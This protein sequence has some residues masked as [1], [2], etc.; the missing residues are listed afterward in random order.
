MMTPSLW[1]RLSVSLLLG[2][3]A[4]AAQRPVLYP[5]EQYTRGGPA[6]AESA[7]DDCMRRASEFMSS[8]SRNQEAARGVATETAVGAGAGAAIGAVGG[9]ISGGAGEGAAVGAATGGTAGFLHGMFRICE[10]GGPPD[11]T[12]AAFVDRCLREKGYE[13]IGW[14]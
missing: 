8:S 5:N 6:V 2:L 4:C 3:S 13:P 10:P 12:F 7:V 14:K 11:P 9:A 1:R